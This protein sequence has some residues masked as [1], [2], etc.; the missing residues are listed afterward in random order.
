MKAKQ[1]IS[2]FL[3]AAFLCAFAAAGMAAGTLVLPENLT[4]I[5]AEAF[6]GNTS[7]DE[8]VLPEGIETIGSRAFADSSIA[9]INLPSSITY[10][11]EDAFE[12]CGNLQMTAQ[13]GSYAYD[14]ATAE[15]LI[16]SHFT[17]TV[18][19][20]EA[21]ITGYN[22]SL[23]K[24]II[25]Q[26]I[27]GNTVTAIASKAFQGRS[28]LT[29]V[30]FP[31]TLK[32]IGSYAFDGC[33]GLDG[34]IVFPPDLVLEDRAFQYCSGIDDLDFEGF[35][36]IA[37]GSF[38]YCTG[39]T[40]LRLL[41]GYTLWDNTVDSDGIFYGCTNL[42]KIIWGGIGTISD[43]AVDANSTT[44]QFHE[45]KNTLE[46]VVYTNGAYIVGEQFKNFT[47]LKR[48]TFSEK[49]RVVGKHAFYGCTNLELDLDLS[50]VEY[51]GEYAFYNCKK[52]K[53]LKL[54]NKLTN[55]GTYAFYNCDG[56]IGTLYVNGSDV[57]V[58]DD[59]FSECS[60]ITKV[61]FCADK[62]ELFVSFRN[63][64][65][66]EE[67]ILNSGVDTYYR[68]VD[69]SYAINNNQFAGCK[70]LKKLTIGSTS[71]SS[72]AITQNMLCELRDTLETLVLNN[73]V[74]A[75]KDKA[76]LDFT[77]LRSIYIP[78]TVTEFGSDV[79]SGCSTELIIYGNIGSC[80]E[81]YAN[82]NKI[83]FIAHEL[84]SQFAVITD[85]TLNATPT[86]LTIP[87]GNQLV[88][89][90][91]INAGSALLVDVQ[92]SV[93]LASDHEQ[94]AVYERAESIGADTFDLSGLSPMTV[95]AEYNGFAMTAGNSYDVVLYVTDENGNGFESDPS[96]RVNV[97][98]PGETTWYADVTDEAGNALT[99]VTLPYTGEYA[100][101]IC[102]RTNNGNM[103]AWVDDGFPFELELAKPIELQADGSYLF[104]YAI[105]APLDMTGM[106]KTD[107]VYF[108][109]RDENDVAITDAP[110]AQLTI[111]QEANVDLPVIYSIVDSE[112][113]D[114]T[115][116]PLTL[117]YTGKCATS[118]IVN[119]NT[120]AITAWFNVNTSIDFGAPEETLLEDGTYQLVY[121]NVTANENVTA[122]DIARTCVFYAYTTD[123][124]QP[125]KSRT[126]AEVRVVQEGNPNIPIVSS[127]A[128][129]LD[130]ITFHRDN[131]LKL[132]VG[133]HNYGNGFELIVNT[134]NGVLPTW[135]VYTDDTDIARAY[136]K[137]GLVYVHAKG[138][139]TTGLYIS[140]IYAEDYDD[141]SSE[142]MYKICDIEVSSPYNAIVIADPTYRYFNGMPE[143]RA[144]SERTNESD[145]MIKFFLNMRF[146][147]GTSVNTIENLYTKKSYY[148]TTVTQYVRDACAELSTKTSS[149]SVT[150]VYI[151]C[152]GD[153]D[154]NL[155]FGLD[156]S[157][158]KD[159]PEY[160]AQIGKY[161][162]SWFTLSGLKSI[163][164]QI[165]GRVVLLLGSCYSGQAI[166]EI[167]PIGIK[168]YFDGV[169]N[170]RWDSEG[171]FRNENKYF[172]ITAADDD[173]PSH[174]MAKWNYDETTKT[175]SINESKSY[176]IFTMGLCNS[177]SWDYVNSSTPPT[178]EYSLTL[179][180]VH[181]ALHQY[182]E[183]AGVWLER[184]ELYEHVQMSPAAE[185]DT[186]IFER[187]N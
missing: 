8:V 145:A 83:T 102:V 119:S 78:D 63:C 11:A 128:I 46:E 176:D 17:Y 82:E 152:H 1:W 182:V 74:Y 172:V 124:A 110:L 184:E 64:V 160:D 39:L 54:G 186:V 144:I 86:E 114:L 101:N 80:A 26:E 155:I 142:M 72:G 73:G 164:D 106:E 137:D 120:K 22:G 71:A 56:I 153:K 136:R 16:A 135:T 51:I 122:S 161:P 98:E 177:L 185:A 68:Y 105:S 20:G 97:V 99:S 67:A 76:F 70:K 52:V 34:T 143:Y 146:D 141:V 187:V 169:I 129:D 7:L 91:T 104:T 23:K 154:G 5:K 165:N 13:E 60:G 107:T 57:C 117:D 126:L 19:N 180:D 170:G 125:D 163:L 32:S 95:G 9:S 108:C 103:T 47:S 149:N 100:G 81:A 111:T 84:P 79:F 42:R 139:G 115:T 48:V 131:S 77:E 53:N 157:L 133:D 58:H 148:G 10:I 55:I 116:M 4:E 130:G 15:G 21:T 69:V 171:V 151:L 6:E 109:L 45:L 93:F 3:L 2:I 37:L 27:A 38:R 50:D 41:H 92:A 90:G 33:S 96:I 62:T 179:K 173:E 168:E 167:D 87:V 29:Y 24:I 174:S 147:N 158:R 18:A 150:F 35:I 28:D 112:G 88:F 121:R 181:D 89:G 166:D 14:W 127:A 113:N 12:G 36:D 118:V 30:S 43:V 123:A 132:I 75:I 138:C 175:Y 40:E 59:A 183:V 140:H 65:N 44:S 94:G 49:L 85:Y 25:P 61:V 159:D 162:Y 134:S 156:A 31:N 66:L 178:T